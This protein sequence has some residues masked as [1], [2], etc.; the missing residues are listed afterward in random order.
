MHEC[1]RNCSKFLPGPQHSL[2]ASTQRLQQK[3]ILCPV[4]AKAGSDCR[5][6]ADTR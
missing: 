5:L 2:R 1:E 6:T 3:P 4:P